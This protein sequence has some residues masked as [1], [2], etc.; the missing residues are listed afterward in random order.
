MELSIARVVVREARDRPI[1]F[2]EYDTRITDMREDECI[3]D[4][5]RK[6]YSYRV[7]IRLIYVL[8]EVVKILRNEC[9]IRIDRLY[10]PL[11]LRDRLQEVILEYTRD[12]LLLTSQY[13]KNSDSLTWAHTMRTHESPGTSSYMMENICVNHE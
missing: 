11:Y 9:K 1:T 6:E 12:T 7:P 2:H 3:I 4:E 13:T 5:H 8:Y 10:I